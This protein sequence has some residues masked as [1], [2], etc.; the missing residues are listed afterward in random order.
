MGAA[1]ILQ[2]LREGDRLTTSEIAQRLN[3]PVC[4]IQFGMRRLLKDVSEKIEFR[5]L[6]P[7]EKEIRFGRKVGSRINIYWLDE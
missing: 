3:S 6:T 2:I 5:L 4:A 7:E 1:E